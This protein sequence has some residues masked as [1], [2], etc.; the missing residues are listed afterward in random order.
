V[1]VASA[2]HDGV[3]ALAPVRAELGARRAAA[4]AHRSVR[5][6]GRRIGPESPADD[7]HRLRTPAPATA[8]GRLTVRLAVRQAAP[9]EFAR[10]FAESDAAE[11]QRV[12]RELLARTAR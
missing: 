8:V 2:P 12:H 3:V 6:R 7:L 1:L 11:V 10:R 9:A 5:R 4:H